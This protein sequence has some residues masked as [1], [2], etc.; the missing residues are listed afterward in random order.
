MRFGVVSGNWMVDFDPT[1]NCVPSDGPI[2]L[3]PA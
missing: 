3:N 1:N 2:S